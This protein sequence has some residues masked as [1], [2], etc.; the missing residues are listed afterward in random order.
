MI[1]LD[2]SLISGEEVYFCDL[3]F[4]VVAYCLFIL[5]FTVYWL[6]TVTLMFGYIFSFIFVKPSGIF[7]LIL[8]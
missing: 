4:I 5:L 7:V 8:I 6:V 2:H 1:S 3:L